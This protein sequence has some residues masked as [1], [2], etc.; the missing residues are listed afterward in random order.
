MVI[1]SQQPLA[2]LSGGKPIAS[3]ALFP[4][5]ADEARNRGITLDVAVKY[6]RLEG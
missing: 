4:L 2:L 5:L 3:D 6:F 1:A